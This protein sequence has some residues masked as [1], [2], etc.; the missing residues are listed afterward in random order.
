MLVEPGRVY[1]RAKL[2][3]QVWGDGFA[4]SDRT[5]DSHIKSL[6]RK[7]AEA[8]GDAAVI[9]T[10]RGVGYRVAPPAETRST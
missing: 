1:T 5:V 8:G 4:M 10:V 7:V 6:R 9:E 3:D 2:I